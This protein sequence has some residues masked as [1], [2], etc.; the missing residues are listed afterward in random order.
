MCIAPQC[1]EVSGN[2][3]KE[4]GGV[5]RSDLATQCME[6]VGR[7]SDVDN[8]SGG[9]EVGGERF[10]TQSPFF[11]LYFYFFFLFFFKY[12]L[13]NLVENSSVNRDRSE[14]LFL[15]STSKSVTQMRIGLKVGAN[16]KTRNGDVTSVVHRICS[17]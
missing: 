3:G 9:G 15:E 16:L 7:G 11:F 13:D 17:I 6:I 2:G 1:A 8:E 10:Q 5:E 14:H 12:V 4:R